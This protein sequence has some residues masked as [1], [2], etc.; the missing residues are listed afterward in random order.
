MASPYIILNI[1]NSN[2]WIQNDNYSVKILGE[3]MRNGK[4]AIVGSKIYE[5]CII[6]LEQ[7]IEIHRI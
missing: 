5:M 1:K 2:W 6:L 7:I 3:N 4:I